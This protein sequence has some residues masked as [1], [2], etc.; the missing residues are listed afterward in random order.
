VHYIYLAVLVILAAFTATALTHGLLLRFKWY[1]IKVGKPYL[2]DLMVRVVPSAR[3]GEVVVQPRS[4]PMAP[5]F[6]F[7]G[8][9]LKV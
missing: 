6:P 4:P 5:N 3:H 8:G 2:T 7:P 1:R 9:K